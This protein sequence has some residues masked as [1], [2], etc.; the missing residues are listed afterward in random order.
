MRMSDWSSEVC[1]SDLIEAHRTA[2]D[3]LFVYLPERWAAA[4]RGV[5]DDFDLHDHLKAYTA[6][7]AIPLQIVRE[8]RALSYPCKAS[9]MWRI[10]LALYAKAGGVPWKLADVEP[11]TAYI[12][13]SYAV[14]TVETDKPRFVTC[15]R[16]EA[17]TCE[18]Q[19][20]MRNPYAGCC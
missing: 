3:V 6:A 15:C 13:L 20:L 18:I 11:D 1:S 19:S 17:H 14:R 16:S 9:V 12:G 10:G 4:F 8:G 2:F 5:E 7:H